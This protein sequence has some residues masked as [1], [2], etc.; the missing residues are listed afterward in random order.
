M[1]RFKAIVQYDGTNYFGF[2]VQSGPRTIQGELERV[3]RSLAAQ[4]K[5]DFHPLP[6]PAILESKK[7]KLKLNKTSLDDILKEITNQCGVRFKRDGQKVEII[8]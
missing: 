8:P 4:T 6:L 1:T 5:L 3:I 7:V 2:Q